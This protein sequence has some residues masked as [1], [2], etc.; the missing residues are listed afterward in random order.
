[1]REKPSK[2]YNW[3]AFLIANILVEIPYQIFA[4]VLTFASYYY[5]VVGNNQSSD[6][7]GLV[8][9][10]CI[11]LFIYASAFAHMCIAALP[12]AQTAAAIV[13]LLTMMSTLFSG[14]LQSPAALPG[15]WVFMYRLSP[16]SYWI[17]GIV[18]TQL[19][20]RE[21]T[22][23][24]AETNRFAPPNG[25]MCSDYLASFLSDATGYLLN[26]NSTTECEYCSVRVADQYVAASNIYWSDRWR[27]FGI[28][29]AYILFNIAVAVSTYYLFRVRKW[30]KA[31]VKKTAKKGKQQQSKP[32]ESTEI[33]IDRTGSEMSKE[34]EKEK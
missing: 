26:P 21:V 11:Q 8:L 22:C 15:F 1:M 27:N 33:S 20:G 10:F 34:K 2:A 28:M 14:V 3:S 32:N 23:S 17:S 5:A 19:H 24:A 12:D 13:T 18:S 4:A 25:M 30:K 29:W 16:F 7:Q 6:R 9:L 31:G